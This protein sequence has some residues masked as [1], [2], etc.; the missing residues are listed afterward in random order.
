[1][2]CKVCSQQTEKLCK[3]C[4]VPCCQVHLEIH[5]QSYEH[6]RTEAIF[7]LVSEG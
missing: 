4:L 1:M 2:N 3:S 7:D 5:E 6:R